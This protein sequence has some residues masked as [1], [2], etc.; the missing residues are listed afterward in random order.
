MFNDKKLQS[1]FRFGIMI[2]LCSTL[3][4]NCGFT[5]NNS[6]GDGVCDVSES[7]TSCAA[8]CPPSL[9]FTNG[10]GK[11]ELTGVPTAVASVAA[12]TELTVTLPVDS[13]TSVAAAL[14]MPLG[15]NNVANVKAYNVVSVSSGS[16]QSVVLT[17]G[18]PTNLAQAKYY[19]MVDLAASVSN[20]SANTFTRY[21][22]LSST[23]STYIFRS[24]TGGTS[25]GSTDTKVNS[26]QI[27]VTA[28]ASITATAAA[29]S[30]VA[31]TPTALTVS[32]IPTAFTSAT[33]GGLPCYFVLTMP[34]AL[35]SYSISLDSMS[36]NQDLY[37]YYNDATFTTLSSSSINT[38][39]TPDNIPST[40]SNA[41]N[42]LYIKVLAT[43]GNSNFR[44]V[45]P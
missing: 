36:L 29:C 16:A 7:T 11:P 35:T 1:G 3:L 30:T 37:S 9:T 31:G 12:A 25:P 40:M 28:P 39:T 27:D 15:S 13:D 2:F 42:K 6:C 38:G 34:A 44:L 14:I 4:M 21:Y 18:I 22:D 45:T 5:S 10:D 41:T 26:V 33:G 24:F 23:G 8:D 19:I 17:F 32:A 43:G 20:Y